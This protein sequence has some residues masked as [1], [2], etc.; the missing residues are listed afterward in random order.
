LCPRY[1]IGTEDKERNDGGRSL[2]L[3][4]ANSSFRKTLNILYVYFM[5]ALKVP[6][7]GQPCEKVSMLIFL[8]VKLTALWMANSRL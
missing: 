1:H 8:T 7:L 5:F 3:I 4:V 6:G 2:K